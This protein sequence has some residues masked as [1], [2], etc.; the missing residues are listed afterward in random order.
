MDKEFEPLSALDQVQGA[1][2]DLGK[3]LFGNPTLTQEDREVLL[4][5]YGRLWFALAL[6]ARAATNHPEMRWIRKVK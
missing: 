5:V 1:T 3:V 6:E 4:D 2:R